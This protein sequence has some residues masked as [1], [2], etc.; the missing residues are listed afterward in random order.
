[1][2]TILF[3]T[4][5]YPYFP[6]EQFIEDEVGYWAA[7]K[8]AKVVLVPM[9]ASGEPRHVP[10]GIEVDLTLAHSGS[11]MDK[12]ACV[13]KAFFSKLF[14][15]EASLIYASKRTKL[16]C[17]AQALK[18]TAH[19]LLIE[20]ALRRIHS[21]HQNLDVAYCYWNDVQAYATIL[22]KRDGFISKVVSRAHGFDLYESR[23]REKYMPL[24]RQFID[25]ID[26]IFAISKEGKNYLQTTYLAAADQ[27]IVSPLGVP[28]PSKNSV[29]SKLNQLNIVS[30]SFCVP[31]K[32]I[33]KI[34]DAIAEAALRFESM[35]ISWVH[36]GDGP[37]LP[38]LQL[39]AVEKFNSLQI[40]WN[41]LGKKSN[42]EVKQYFEKNS[43]DVFINT[44]ESEGVPVSIMEAMSYGVPVI[45]P[46]VGGVSELVANDYGVLLSEMASVTEIAMAIVEMAQKCKQTDVRMR[47][48]NK[49][50][51]GYDAHHNY[52][53]FI[54]LVIH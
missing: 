39:R 21:N 36:I 44:S 33:D 5:A 23:R 9:T 11:F 6:G 18:S 15:K 26:L 49:I 14:W 12:L 38:E 24:K 50:I 45:A 22:L 17:Y 4:N 13:A 20:K 19:V 27:V 29:A 47:A 34:I 1:M 37:L 25:D 43:V 41:F 35:S 52:K 31:V 42:P 8:S 30:V 2:K 32:R 16:R 3:L 54:N 7:Q 28:I 10:P 48:K 46:N 51:S 53:N 40:E